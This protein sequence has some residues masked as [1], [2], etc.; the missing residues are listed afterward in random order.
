MNGIWPVVGSTCRWRR[1]RRDHLCTDGGFLKWGYPL[2]SSKSWMILEHGDLVISHFK[3]P[4]RCLRHPAAGHPGT[5]CEAF[6]G[7]RRI[8][9]ED[10][11]RREQGRTGGVSGCDNGWNWAV[12]GFCVC[13]LVELKGCTLV[14]CHWAWRNTD[15]DCHSI[16]VQIHKRAIVHSRRMF[17]DMLGVWKQT[18]GD[19]HTQSP[20]F[21]W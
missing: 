12:Q 17:L 10:G 6:Q 1:S 11:D 18:W 3:N 16:Y 19:T 13:D 14:V 5:G 4:R 7:A 2:A 20:A 8:D 9:R 15:K 21:Q